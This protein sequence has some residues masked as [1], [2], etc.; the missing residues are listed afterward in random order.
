MRRR[1]SQLNACYVFLDR[2][3]APTL[4][5]RPP[6]LHGSHRRSSRW[7]TWISWATAAEARSQADRRAGAVATTQR[8]VAN[9]CRVSRW[10]GPCSP[11]A[12]VHERRLVRC[13]AALPSKYFSTH[14]LFSLLLAV[15]FCLQ[16]FHVAKRTEVFLLKIVVSSSRI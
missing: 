2:H 14:M 8:G 3:R 7:C 9:L 6:I 5:R 13:T 12:A 15:F 11:L 16:T 1:H 10:R 4:L